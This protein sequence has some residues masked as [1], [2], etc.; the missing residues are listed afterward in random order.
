MKQ[1]FTARTWTE[2]EWIIAQ[3]A[4]VDVASHGRTEQEALHNLQEALELYFEPPTA[5]IQPKVATLEVELG[6]A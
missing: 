3:C 2:G 6:A 4:E 1:I 5:T